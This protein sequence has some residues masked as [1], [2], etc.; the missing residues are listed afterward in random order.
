MNPP[1]THLEIERKFIV[2]QMP[3]GL[4]EPRSYKHIRQ[5]YIS[6]GP[7]AEV[8]LRDKSGV[9][10]L[11]VKKGK[12]KVR[13]ETEIDLSQEQFDSLWPLTSGQRV[14][15]RRYKI[16]YFDVDLEIDVFEGNNEPL[17]LLEVEFDTVEE[18]DAFVIPDFVAEEVTEDSRYNNANLATNGLPL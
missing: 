2:R 10:T 18:C 7:E 8:R 3:E 14:E 9:Y 4:L 16:N 11:T 17:M 6:T 1:A 15:K 12:G 5:G 13:S